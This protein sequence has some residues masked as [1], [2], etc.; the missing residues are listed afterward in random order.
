MTV[1]EPST[2][3]NSADAP[4]AGDE[5]LAALLTRWLPRQRW[6]AG[7]EELTAGV[8]VTSRVPVAT[9]EGATFEHLL[10]E[11]PGQHD[12]AARRYQLWIGHRADL[13]ARM[14]HSEIGI[15]DGP[16]P[17]GT[18]VYD[19]LHDHALT[20]ILLRAI[21]EGAELGDVRASATP[22]ADLD[23]TAPGLVISGEQSNTSVV[24]GESAILKLFRRLEPGPNPDAELHAA[25]GRKSSAHAARLLGELTGDVDG[26]P[27]TLGVLTEFFANSADGWLAATASVRDLMAE[28][29]LRA[30]EVGG[31]FAAEARRLGAAVAEVHRDL[32]DAF[33]TTTVHAD[34]LRRTLTEMATTAGHSIA[35]VPELAEYGDRI[36]ATFEEAGSSAASLTLQ[37]I[38]GDLHL[39][40][41]LRTLTGWAIIDFEGEPSKPLAYR[42]AM[43][44]PLRDVAGMLRSFDYAAHHLLAGS[45]AD[46]QHA[47][48][49]TEWAGRNRRAF[50]DGYAAASAGDPR[51]AGILLRAFELDKAVY[52]VQ[53]E[54]DHRPGWVPIPLHAVAQLTRSGGTS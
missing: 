15:L 47:F 43:H 49:A 52:E 39:G 31:D 38:H 19:A 14:A 37:R 32:A 2:A 6:F 41:T 29:D 5:A 23:V 18:V 27:T 8:T 25:L 10:V 28:G 11:V 4:S 51:N 20:T 50:C 35:A 34:E 30:D 26:Q 1:D 54:H 16:T 33:G 36:L 22:G 44:S 45:V 53:Y 17:T 3:Q 9:V 46:S 42:R 24:Y 12:N 21:A 7:R 13:P 40:Q 48:R